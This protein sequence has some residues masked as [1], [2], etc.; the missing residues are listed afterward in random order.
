MINATR[1]I[2]SP[3]HAAASLRNVMPLP[4]N[5]LLYFPLADRRSSQLI[6][7][8][9]RHSIA[10]AQL[11]ISYRCQSN[12]QRHQAI[13]VLL[14][15][16]HRLD[17]SILCFAIASLIFATLALA[18]PHNALLVRFFC[19]DVAALHISSLYQLRS[20]SALCY[21]FADRCA[22]LPLLFFAS[23]CDSVTLRVGAC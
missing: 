5:T 16:N 14:F 23:P 11:D 21:R 22:A 17:T 8:Q 7:G 9:S 18:N 19:H 20:L 15:A 6:Y 1:H 12:T 10:T 2:S 4:T 3:F 13:A